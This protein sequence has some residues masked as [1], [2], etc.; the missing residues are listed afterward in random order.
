MTDCVLYL[1]CCGKTVND[2]LPVPI[3]LG[4]TLDAGLAA[5]GKQQI[6]QLA[7]TLCR[8]NLHTIYTSPAYRATETARILMNACDTTMFRIAGELNAVD[9]GSWEGQTWQQ[10]AA[11]DGNAFSAY[12]RDPRDNALGGGETLGAVQARALQ[13]MQKCVKSHPRQQIVVVTHQAV[14]RAAIAG[15]AG[16]PLQRARDLDQTYGCI[17]IIRAVEDKFLVGATNQLV[18]A[19][20]LLNAN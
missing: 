2:A 9:Y 18:V 16:V 8:R 19:E 1:L 3:I 14:I 10:A 7:K 12:L 11:G 13:F 4:R 20:E 6:Q 15:I 5:D 17:N